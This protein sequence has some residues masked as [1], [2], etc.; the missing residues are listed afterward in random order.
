VWTA[1]KPEANDHIQH[2]AEAHRLM[3]K[4]WET[5]INDALL[6]QKSKAN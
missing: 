2:I 4:H 1:L 6:K 3:G 5:T